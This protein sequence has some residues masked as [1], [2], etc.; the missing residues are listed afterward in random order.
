MIWIKAVGEISE[1]YKG[2]LDDRTLTAPILESFQNG[3]LGKK[4]LRDI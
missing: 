4:L 2:E 3:V 1:A